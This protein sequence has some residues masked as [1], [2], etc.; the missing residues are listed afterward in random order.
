VD[1]AAVGTVMAPQLTARE[2]EVAGLV[3]DGCTNKEIARALTIHQATAK[4][5]VSQ[6]LRKLGLQGRVQLAVYTR[7][8]GLTVG[9]A[10]PAS[11]PSLD[12]P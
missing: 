12:T 2:R 9:A 5:H 7:D 3:A 8:S 6:I 10:Q 4:W 1:E 11:R